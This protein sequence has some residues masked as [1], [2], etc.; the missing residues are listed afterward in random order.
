[1]K[2]TAMAI[3]MWHEKPKLFASLRKPQGKLALNEVKGYIIR[4]EEIL[5]PTSLDGPGDVSV[6]FRR[7]K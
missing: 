2:Q 1:M 7:G 4:H 3:G 6:F 5:S